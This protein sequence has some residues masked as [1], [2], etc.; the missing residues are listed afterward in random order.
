[1]ELGHWKLIDGANLKEDSFGFIYNI[2]NTV[3]NKTYIGKK[4]IKFKIRRR[5]LKN[6]KRVRINYVDSDWKEYMGS[7]KELLS[8]IEKFGKEN[9]DFLIIKV[10]N[11]KWE[12]GY[13]EI[14]EQITKDVLLKE[15][16]YNGIINVRIG[17][18]PKSLNS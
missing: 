5:P 4:Q 16:Y 18:P 10:C 11:S 12:L 7:S 8:D 14:K 17:R 1:M 9:F 3:N 13:E 6:K 2:I 15:N